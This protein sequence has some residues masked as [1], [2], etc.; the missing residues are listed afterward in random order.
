MDA[1]R[2]RPIAFALLVLFAGCASPQSQPRPILRVGTSGDYAPFSVVDSEGRRS[3]LDVELARAY[4]GDRGLKIVWVPFRWAELHED[5][6]KGRFDI[7]WSG[8]T[9]RPER[10]VLGTFTVP[11]L[12]SGAVAL[13]RAEAG[14]EAPEHLD[15]PTVRIAVNRGGHLER[16]TRKLFPRAKIAAVDRNEDVLS[17]LTE[18]RADAAITDSVEAPHWEKRSPIPLRRIGPFSQDHKAAWVRADL[19]ERAR[20][21]S[22]WLVTREADGTLARLRRE[23]G[24]DHPLPTAI[25][26]FA[27]ASAVAERLAL[28]PY[29]AEA[30]RRSGAP[31][32]VPER[33]KV[34]VQ[35]GVDATLREAAKLRLPAPDESRVREFYHQQ[36]EQAKAL[37]FDVLAGPGSAEPPPDL[38]EALRPALLRIGDRIAWL[39]VLQAQAERTAEALEAADVP[40]SSPD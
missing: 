15:L 19:V 34:V 38:D 36:I 14:E 10:S 23:A 29:V 9:I 16:V 20:D 13:V 7:A 37:Q 35:A 25:P 2:L 11:T 22:R 40:A 39:L 4:A 28:M 5:F 3:G 12:R 8:V 26:D 27:L 6:R 17:E 33:E 18:G 32:A 21:L 24:L 30:K 1:C 31:V